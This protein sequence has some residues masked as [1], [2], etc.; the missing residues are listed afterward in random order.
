MRR[1]L[2]ISSLWTGLFVILVALP[3]VVAC[4]AKGGG[5]VITNPPEGD[6]A[7]AILL[8]NS[9]S[10]VV[11]LFVDGESFPCCQ[12]GPND[13]RDVARTARETGGQTFTFRAGRNTQIIGNGQCATTR[14]MMVGDLIGRVVW[15]GAV[16]ECIGWDN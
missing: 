12:V 15:N 8:R 11:H 14:A 10:E 5:N 13:T 2:V 7:I 4:G 16:F 3:N 1:T 9:T 6:K